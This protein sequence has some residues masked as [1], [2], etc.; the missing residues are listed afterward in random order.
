M[1]TA[2]RTGEPV[3]LELETPIDTR[4]QRRSRL[5]SAAQL[6]VVIGWSTPYGGWECCFLQEDTG[7]TYGHADVLCIGVKPT[8]WMPLPK[9]RR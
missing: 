5:V 1:D 9:R 3:L 8:G 6:D 2:P 4:H 7:D